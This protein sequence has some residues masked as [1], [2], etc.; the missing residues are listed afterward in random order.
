M[1][2]FYQV[3][4]YD[5]ANPNVPVFVNLTADIIT[6]LLRTMREISASTTMLSMDGGLICTTSGVT[7]TL[8]AYDSFQLGRL[9]S[10]KN[11]STGDVTVNS[12]A[13]EAMQEAG[14][15]ISTITVPSN[16]S[17]YIGRNA[18]NT[19]NWIIQ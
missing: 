5:D 1:A 2:Y 9:Y 17:L 14:G 3:L 6:G 19:V 18:T 11:A 4:R 8:P 13:G 12:A 16:L 7:V 15:S 10:I